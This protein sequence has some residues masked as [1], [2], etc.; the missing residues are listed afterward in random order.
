MEK[1]SLCKKVLTEGGCDVH[2]LSKPY[3]MPTKITWDGKKCS[4][5]NIVIYRIC[6]N[7]LNTVMEA[8]NS[9]IKED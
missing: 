4:L 2:N 8:V 1:C 5:D 6:K 9:C 7:C 3:E